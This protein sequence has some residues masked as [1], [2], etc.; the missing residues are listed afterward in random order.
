MKIIIIQLKNTLLSVFFS[1][2][3]HPVLGK[4]LLELLMYLICATVWCL[5]SAQLHTW[6]CSAVTQQQL[7]VEY[8][9]QGY[10]MGRREKGTYSLSTLDFQTEL[11]HMCLQTHIVQ[12]QEILFL[13]YCF[14]QP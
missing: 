2:C 14:Y 9:A 8:L 12:P 3:F 7:E 11:A 6:V 4:S 1:I 5:T 10:L 13:V